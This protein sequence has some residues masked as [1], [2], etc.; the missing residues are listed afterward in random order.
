MF[1]VFALLAEISW[2]E[3]ELD[4]SPDTKPLLAGNAVFCKD[5][6]IYNFFQIYNGIV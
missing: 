2:P 1:T 4:F 5:V 6:G 3:R